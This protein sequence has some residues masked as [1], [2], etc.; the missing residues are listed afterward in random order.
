MFPGRKTPPLS[1]N[2]GCC[3]SAVPKRLRTFA[4]ANEMVFGKRVLVRL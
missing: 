3:S 4:R 2:S 1:K